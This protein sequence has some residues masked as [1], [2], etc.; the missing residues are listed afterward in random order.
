M[1]GINGV[2][3]KNEAL[4]ADMNAATRHRGP[5]ATAVWTNGR[6]TFGANRLAIIDLSRSADQPMKSDDGRFIITFNGEIYNF[7]ELRAELEG[8]YQFRTHGDTEVILALFKQY[9]VEAF[10]RLN[11]MFAL[12]IWDSKNNELILA[13]DHA[14]IKPLY[15]HHSGAS[16]AFSSEI[17][18]LLADGRIR[19][20]IN[21]DALMRYVRLRYVPEPDTMIEDIKKL[22]PAS[23]AIF[24]DGELRITRYF[25][26]ALQPLWSLKSGE[27]EARI[28]EI[29]DVSVKR[30]LISDRPVGLFLSGGLDSSIV[31]DSAAKAAGTV[32]TFS[33]AFEL[34][35]H[36]QPEKFNADAVLA[37]RTAEFYG[38]RHH[39]V[40]L[41]ESMFVSLLPEAV[42][43][44]DQPIANATAVAQLALARAARESIV[45]ALQGDGGDEL[46]GGYP[47]YSLC[48]AM[49]AYHVLPSFVR[50]GLSVFHPN[51]RK[52]NTLPG[53][54]RVKLFH[55][56]KET[57][58]SRTYA[59]E[60]I[61]DAPARWFDERYLQG[62]GENDFTQLL[63]DV[64]RRTWLPDE[65]LAR[66]DT[67]TMGASLEA[68]VPLLDPELIAFA[69]R[70]PTPQRV[71]FR[72]NK[73]ILRSAF[74]ERLPAHVL[75][76]KKRGFFSPTAKWLRRPKMFALARE[77]LSPGYHRATDRLL[78]PDV[79]TL[80]DQHAAGGYA[81]TQL[82]SLL[83]LRLWARAFNA[84]LV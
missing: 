15:Y 3:G 46:F 27:T 17:K 75:S 22:P 61:S 56:E 35:K 52:L 6:V 70:V 25:E 59:S 28:R 57:V 4:V 78:A 54:E 18:G 29:V 16:F 26:P 64:D 41:S 38:A 34:D 2:T 20:R 79:L 65:A 71:G 72:A 48:R 76:E 9:G 82:W 33:L 49:D 58:L 37:K 51:M 12:A 83:S 80:L 50:A 8:S 69:T 32:E 45:V 42:H 19:R 14:G 66:T 53:I 74:R 23:Y 5:D 24:R 67:M 1:C 77:V 73:R 81:M 44:L 62:R 55:F 43:F 10:S 39:E 11:G 30:Q 47:R 21:R 13:R 60:F 31:L 36:E 7:R 84:E 40:S 68:R 63:M